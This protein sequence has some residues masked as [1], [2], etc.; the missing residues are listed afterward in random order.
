MAL[1]NRDWLPVCDT[2]NWMGKDL[3]NKGYQLELHMCI[4][5]TFHCSSNVLV[6]DNIFD[7]LDK[8]LEYKD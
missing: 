4:V 2:Q 8:G 1:L 6:R 7:L 3:G 5:D